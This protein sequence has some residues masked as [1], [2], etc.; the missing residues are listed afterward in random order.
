MYFEYNVKDLL[1]ELFPG[2][3][4]G[5]RRL[6]KTYIYDK[7]KDRFG[8]GTYA[9]TCFKY[10]DKFWLNEIKLKL[11]MDFR[12]D[13]KGDTGDKCPEEIYAEFLEVEGPQK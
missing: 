1:K 13:S 3:F 8:K 4:A 5:N 9:M 10:E 11:D 6:N 12:N 7:L 2:I